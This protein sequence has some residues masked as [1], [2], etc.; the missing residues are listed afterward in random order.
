MEYKVT[1][2]SG[3]RRVYI[4]RWEGYKQLSKLAFTMTNKEVALAFATALLQDG[5]VE[6]IEDIKS[7]EGPEYDTM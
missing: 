7:I 4:T 6:G 5:H 1:Y 3:D 2:N